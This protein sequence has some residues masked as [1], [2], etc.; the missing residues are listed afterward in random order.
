MMV[1]VLVVAEVANTV[2]ERLIGKRPIKYFDR[3]L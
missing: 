1:F 2:F 3:R